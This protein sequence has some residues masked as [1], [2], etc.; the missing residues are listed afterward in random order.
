MAKAKIDD[1][2]LLDR[3]IQVFRTY[4]FEGASLSRI[5]EATGLQRASLYHR[6]PG[7]KEEMAEAVLARAAQWLGQHALR[8][9]EGPGDPPTRL[10]RMT[11]S[12]REFYESGEKSCLLD[13]LSFDDATSNVHNHIHDAIEYWVSSL[14]RIAREVGLSAA[15]ARRWGEDT[16]IRVQ[17]ALVFARAT[18]KTAAFERILR[19]VPA[20]LM[21]RKE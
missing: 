10:K 16:V 13:A 18:G 12:L 21:E 4:G 11:R 17:G 15:E 6:F 7:G 20:S 5:S 19:E 2:A 1:E 9:L 8:P 3:L 14:T